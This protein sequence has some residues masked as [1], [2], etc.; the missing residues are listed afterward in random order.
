MPQKLTLYG[1]SFSSASYRARIAL[2]LKGLEYE[3]VSIKVPAGEQHAPEYE[4]L[5]PE[6]LIPTLRHGDVTITQSLA[7]TLYLDEVF[8]EIPLRPATAVERAHSLAFALA[9]ACEIHPL[10][11]TRVL[12]Y[13]TGP[14]GQSGAVRQS[15]YEHWIAEGLRPLETIMA[16]RAIQSPFCFG[17]APGT[18]DICLI[19]QLAN[20][21]RMKCDVTPYPTLTRIEANCLA[22]DAFRRAMPENQPKV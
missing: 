18:A 20:A 11:N 10:N 8:P 21:R 7:I 12:N 5:N 17:E 3:S 6:R 15:W 1:F 19:P 9:I 14:L 2:N 13:V 22:L 16:R 4:A